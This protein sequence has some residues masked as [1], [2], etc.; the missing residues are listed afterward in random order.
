MISKLKSTD[1]FSEWEIAFLGEYN[2]HTL[3]IP[4]LIKG[5]GDKILWNEVPLQGK[6]LS[7]E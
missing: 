1:G 3:E 4:N 7:K 5:N 2:S 6:I